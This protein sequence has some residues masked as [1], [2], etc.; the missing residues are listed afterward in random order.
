MQTPLIVESAYSFEGSNITM[1]TLFAFAKQRGLSHIA[2][3]DTTMHAAYK[4]LTRAKQQ[5]VVPVLGLSVSYVTID[6][7]P[8]PLVLYAKNYEGYGNLLKLASIHSVA[9]SIAYESL[10]AHGEG[11]S[12]LINTKRLNDNSLFAK[13]GDNALATITEDLK[14]LDMVVYTD[15]YRPVEGAKSLKVF[16]ARYARED[17]VALYQTLCSIHGTPPKDDAGALWEESAV[18]SANN[19]FVQTHGLTFDLPGATLPAFPTPGG[20]TSERYMRALAIKGLGKRLNKRNVNIET[21]RKRLDKELKVI[22]DLGFNDYFLIVWDIVK[23]AKQSNILVGPGRGSAPGSLVAY[24]LGITAIDPIEHGLMFERFLNAARQTMPDIDIDFPDHKRERVVRYLKDR[25]GS[26]Y[27]AL[28]CTFGTFLKKS[29]L[30][31]TARVLAIDKT[32]IEQIVKSVEH[33]D[34]IAGMLEEDADVQNRASND[35]NIGKWLEIAK[36]SEG[37]PRHVSTHAA[38]VMISDRPLIEHTALQEG[39]NTLYQTQ[40]EQ[41]DLEA[42]GLLKM[43]VLG[44]KNLTMIET[45]VERV[46]E[47]YGKTID[48]EKLPLDDFAAFELLRNKSTTGIFQ[49]ESRGMR[50]LIR[51]LE[52]RNFEDIAIALA[53]YRPGPMESIP[54]F[55]KRRK[56]KQPFDPIA[57]EI[58]SILSVTNGIVLYQEQIMAIARIFAGYSLNEADILRRAISKKSRDVLASERNNFIKKAQANGK[59]ESKANEIYDYIV[60][61]ADYGFNKSHSVAYGMVAYWM[62]YLKAHYPDVFITVLMDNAKGNATQ[63]RAYMQEIKEHGLVLKGPSLQVSTL[64]FQSGGDVIHYPLSGV[65]YVGEKAAKSFLEIRDASMFSDFATFITQSRSVL[66]AQHYEYLIYSGAMDGFSLNKRTMVENLRPLINV[67]DYDKALPIEEFVFTHYDEYPRAQLKELETRAIGFNITYDE[68]GPY[69]KY[70]QKH[71]LKWPKDIDALP[72]KTTVRI[73][74]L[75]SRH[76]PITTK[77]GEAMAFLQIEDR[78][79]QIDAVC[80]PRAYAQYASDVEADAVYVFEG[81]VEK[82][83]DS[84]QFVVEKMHIPSV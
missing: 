15:D 74:G 78:V 46:F 50:R 41:S 61:F 28:I 18:E 81:K 17:D 20:E 4:F 3:T 45:V 39:L 2:L 32:R 69:E 70:A 30:R 5:N 66:N 80:F 57:P 68:F 40:Y 29:A 76:K 8:L 34:S 48:V 64:S 44:L 47:L 16:T 37:L 71:N 63:M 43:D 7:S 31:D 21:Y 79:Q 53:L 1:D 42:L 62:A 35:E 19:A 10:K 59:S 73:L 26:E 9:G 24:A 51:Q 58:K 22:N 25:Y 60:K 82:K 33:Y 36:K 13:S 54:D 12:V 72:L 11:L 14:A 65:K 56:S 84:K 75:L 77:K 55:L 27:V 67:I 52:V 49:L 83:S 6:K 23:Y 38:G